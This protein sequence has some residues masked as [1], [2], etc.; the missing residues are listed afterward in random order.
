MKPLS[1]SLGL[2]DGVMELLGWFLQEV[3]VDSVL[4]H[5]YLTDD[6]KQL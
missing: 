3:R 2:L 1:T 6:N 5:D 4:G